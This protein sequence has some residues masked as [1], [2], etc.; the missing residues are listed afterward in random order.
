MYVIMHSR[1]LST[2][3]VVYRWQWVPGLQSDHAGLNLRRRS[4]VVFTNLYMSNVE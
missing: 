3:L 4:E 2:N 1:T